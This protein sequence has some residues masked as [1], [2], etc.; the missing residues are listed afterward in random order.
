MWKYK[1]QTLIS[2]TGLAV[3]FICFALATIWIVYEMSYD[4]FYKNTSQL[5]VVYSPAAR[6]QIGYSR[7]STP[8]PLAAHLKE[9]F[10][11][12]ANAASLNPAQSNG[13]ITVDGVEFPALIITVDS[14]FLTM[15]DV[16]IL[17]GNREFLI[18]ENRQLV[19]VTQ[20]KARELFGFEH[21]IGKTVIRGSAELTIV[22]VVSGLS[23][24]SNYA[25]DFIQPMM[26]MTS[27]DSRFVMFVNT[28]IELLP[29][30]N[31]EA[32]EKKL[33]ENETIFNEI[34]KSEKIKMK[35]ITKVRY[36]DQEIEREVKF[37]HIIVF[38][39]SGL[40]VIL[41]SLF[42]YLTLF[43]SRF[44]MRQ[45]EL[46]LRVVC[47][48]SGGSLLAMLSVEFIL[49][50]LFSVSFGCIITLL[51]YKPFL[52]LSDI[53][54]NLSAIYRESLMYIAVV[55]LVSLLLFWLIL[56]IFRRRTLNLSIRSSNKK[57]F[58]KAS[59]VVQLLI[60]VGFAF[61]TIVILKQMYFLHH[62]D[63]LGFSYKNSGSF[64]VYGDNGE[65][66]ANQMKQTPEITEVIYQ[67]GLTNLLP[68]SGRT[69]RDIVAWDDKSPDEEKISLEQMYV[70]PEFIT[71]YD[72][73]LLAGEMLTD[74]DPESMV[75]LDENAVKAFGWH[76]PV[77]K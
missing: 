68:Q 41:C 17:E 38:A 18:P 7:M 15:F 20:E 16:K 2:M 33:Y 57:L 46:A 5:Y 32:F 59:I 64:I 23:G 67:K 19:A 65:V 14:S 74:A 56:F 35:P 45:K 27:S 10:P 22:A 49:T 76:D 11:E 50:L 26:R 9:T 4:S 71:F 47:G 43:V 62:T 42:N 53:S 36:T 72:F 8:H 12:I 54:M 44:R 21:P 34:F 25:F 40:L 24:Q 63:E 73:R 29:G 58:R 28:V 1:S 13:K 61:C 69:S 77:G 66:L 51:L 30:T 31:I 39:I 75:L 52:T 55:M 60:S 3:G 70:S 37:Q 6:S 48:A